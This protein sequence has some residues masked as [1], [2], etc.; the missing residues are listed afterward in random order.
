MT[1]WVPHILG[2]R[3]WECVSWSYRLHVN[4][5]FFIDGEIGLFEFVIQSVQLLESGMGFF[6]LEI[7]GRVYLRQTP[8][9]AVNRSIVE[10]LLTPRRE[11]IARGSSCVLHG[12][13][14]RPVSLN[15]P[16][17]V[18]HLGV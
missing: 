17:L 13:L 15:S 5:P 4:T 12:I 8:I 18:S 11:V 14:F 10:L 2:R 16:T 9:E 6:E 3:N 7:D 1:D